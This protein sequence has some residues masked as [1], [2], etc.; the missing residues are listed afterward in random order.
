MTGGFLVGPGDE[1]GEA[2]AYPVAAQ[3][4]AAVTD[5]T[6][7]VVAGEEQLSVG[8]DLLQYT[9][10]CDDGGDGDPGD[11]PLD[12]GGEVV[13]ALVHGGLEL[14]GADQMPR[15][16]AADG[17]VGT[18]AR[19]HGEDYWREGVIPTVHYSLC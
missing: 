13:A 18:A 7:V 10:C 19:A 14:A 3:G 5:G 15:L 16:L 12:T 1:I 9:D 11:V 8:D 6:A 17:R 2:F 4:L